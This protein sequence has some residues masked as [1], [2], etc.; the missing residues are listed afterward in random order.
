MGPSDWKEH[1]AGKTPDRFQVGNLPSNYEGPGI[2]ELGV[3][4]PAWLPRNDDDSGVL[5]SEDVVVVYLGCADNVCHHLQRFGQT[6]AH[7]EG[8]RLVRSSGIEHFK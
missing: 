8:A 5:K 2:Y 3:T 7:L 6:G 4:P 1:A